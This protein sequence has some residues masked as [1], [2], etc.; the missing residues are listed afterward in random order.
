MSDSSVGKAIDRVPARKKSPARGAAGAAFA[1]SRGS[2]LIGPPLLDSPR[3]EPRSLAVLQLPARS[4]NIR[5]SKQ[6]AA[7]AR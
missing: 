5:A 1:R 6:E 4:D 7:C 3:R 2:T